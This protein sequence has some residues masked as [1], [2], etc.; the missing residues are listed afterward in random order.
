MKIRGSF[1]RIVIAAPASGSGKTLLTCGILKAFSMR[2]TRSAAF[3]CGPDY[4]DPMFHET[5]LKTP[6][7]NLDTFLAGRELTKA[8]FAED[9]GGADIAVIEGVMGYFDGIAGQRVDASTCDVAETLDAPVIL[10]VDAAKSSVSVL[11]LLKG[12]LEFRAANQIRGVIFNR[13]SPSRYPAVKKMTEESLGLRVCGYL[14]KM[15]GQD[16]SLESRHLGLVMPG[17]V[18]R[19]QEVMEKLGRQ[20]LESLDM[21]LLE[22]IAK[23]APQLEAEIGE[24][25]EGTKERPVIAVARDEAFSFYYKD[26]LQL[27]R[28]LGAE[29]C[30][31]SPLRD[32]HVPK[33]A[34][35]LLLGG[36]YPELHAG[37]LSENRSMR[38]AIQRAC[39]SGMPCIAECG[40]FLYLLDRLTDRQEKRWE[41]AG[42]LRGES[43][44]TGRLTRFGYV[45]LTSR[46]E[47]MLSSEGAR[48]R[49]HEFH[50][51]D[52]DSN[53]SAYQ[54]E[55]PV[56]GRGWS[57]VHGTESLYAGFPHLYLYSSPEAAERFVGRAVRYGRRK[58]RW[59]P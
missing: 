47:Q 6:S 55:K 11:A 51:M 27:L 8:L 13:L 49:G 9:A 58:E 32:P 28:N 20:C 56:T 46:K 29:L 52:T 16:I 5:V 25:P 26:N 44:Y 7:K 4:I 22:K 54:A 41:M 57:C 35:A 21:E 39:L 1:P 24:F 15:D 2:G 43:R 45:E 30:F 36:G 18:E 33:E 38:S 53:G 12:F 42:V 10:V 59:K 14:P 3:K 34:D 37:E 19:I 17:E 50:Y 40:G 48:V 31:F 23:E